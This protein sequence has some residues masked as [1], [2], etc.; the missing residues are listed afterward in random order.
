MGA[1]G[2]YLSADG[3][4]NFIPFQVL[5]RN[6]AGPYPVEDHTL[7]YLTQGKWRVERGGLTTAFEVPFFWAGFHYLGPDVMVRW[8]DS[9][10]RDSYVRGRWPNYPR[11]SGQR[12][13]CVGNLDQVG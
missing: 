8:Q 9:A 13:F 6:P 5:K 7:T 11:L 10:Q 3:A 4:L 1:T 12:Q 2:L